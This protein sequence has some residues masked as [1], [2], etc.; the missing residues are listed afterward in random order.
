M[1]PP[2]APVDALTGVEAAELGL[3][4]HFPFC[5]A[6]CPYCDFAVQVADVIPEERYTRAILAELAQRALP[7]RT[8]DSIFFGG[9]TPSL[10]HPRW[11]GKVLDAVQ[12]AF[13]VSPRAE[14]SLEANPET[15]T[16]ER[17]T[18]LRAAGVNRLSL[19]VQ[20]F[21][22]AVLKTLGRAHA[23]AQAEAAVQAARAAGF[24][25]L[26][27]DLIHGVPGQ[28]VERAV[29]DAER[30]MAL[31]VTHCSAYALT[32]EAD[33]LAEPTPFSRRHQR[34]ELGLPADDDSVASADAMGDV[35][36][37]QG[38][39]RYEISNFAR[40]GF[41]SRHNA[42][43]WTGGEYLALG[44]GATGMLKR[45]VREG[46]RTVNLRST[47][48][49][50]EAVEAGRL[51]TATEEPLTAHELFEERLAMGLRLVSGVDVQRVSARFGES[52]D[53][54]R[55]EETGRM[56]ENGL[57][58]WRGERLALTPRG[59]HLHSEVCARLF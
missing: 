48:R 57:A 26:S 36:R 23:P 2:A 54:R 25:N 9:G 52:W 19:G 3:Y 53:A 56:V 22:A 13:R 15:L 27:L 51:P 11:V 44:V 35:F 10:W 8:L 55:V 50:L 49:Y 43:Y 18:D 39:V 28:T 4:I 1:S 33:A 21:D 59:M 31:E 20:S 29:Q 37:S 14:V 41:S 7:G 45:G 34:G 30:A 32:V 16:V 24:E 17:L 12:G 42:L 58:L 5:L 6:K 47:E 38:L 46:L 40:P